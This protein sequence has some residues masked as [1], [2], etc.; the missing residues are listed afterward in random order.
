MGQ[1]GAGDHDGQVTRTAR[2]SG[3]ISCESHRV[4]GTEPGGSPS[5]STATTLTDQLHDPHPER[6]ER[7]T[8][9]RQPGQS[10]QTRRIIATVNHG[11]WL[12][13]RCSRT[14]RGSRS[15][16]PPS[17]RRA[18]RVQTSGCPVKIEEPGKPPRH[19]A[20]PVLQ[21][22][23][24]GDPDGGRG[25]SLR[26][27]PRWHHAR[28]PTSLV[29]RFTQAGRKW[30]PSGAPEEVSTYDFPSL[31][32]GKANPYG[33]YDIADDSA[34]VSVGVDHDTS[35]FAVATIEQWWEQLGKIKYPNA[36]RL[37]ITADGGGSNGH[38]PW[39]WKFEIARLP[40]ATGLGLDITICHYP[41]GH[42]QM[43]QDRT[44][45]LLQNH[46]KLAWT[47]PGSL[48]NNRQPHR[49]HHHRSRSHGTRRPR[50]QPLPHR[51][52]ADRPA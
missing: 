48:P 45:A 21:A 50:P 7:E 46:R 4:T 3:Q 42:Q 13:S 12:S 11:P 25:S 51:N 32:E 52:Q 9:D 19:A 40:A 16:G 14:Q 26:V 1:A 2:R 27:Q 31:A 15:H 34:W 39:L 23:L 18:A 20:Y 38:R 5:R 37:L 49:Q 43:E 36:T 8:V 35:V 47:T 41:P 24:D 22:R 29:G 10:Q 33:V 44:P 30:R 6:G 28:R 17:F